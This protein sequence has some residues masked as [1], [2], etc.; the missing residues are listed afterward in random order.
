M[1]P[2]VR[3]RAL[4]VLARAPSN[5]NGY[6]ERSTQAAWL[7]AHVRDTVRYI[8]DGIEQYQPTMTTLRLGGDCDDSARALV[9]LAKSVGLQARLVAP[10]G[11]NHALAEIHDGKAWRLA[12]TTLRAARYGEEPRAAL[13]RLRAEGIG[14]PARPDLGSAEEIN[15]MPAGTNKT[16]T[17]ACSGIAPIYAAGIDVQARA[18]ILA[19]WAL[20]PGAPVK[21]PQWLQFAQAICRL[22]S[23]YGRGWKA[24]TNMVGSNNWGATQCGADAIFPGV[25]QLKTK[26]RPALSEIPKDLMPSCKPGCRLSFDTNPDGTYYLVCFREFASPELGAAD[27][28]KHLFK[29]AAVVAAVSSG[30]ATKLS[31]AMYETKYFTGHGSRAEA[32]AAHARA[33]ECHAARIAE[34]VGEPHVI[35]RGGAT[36]AGTSALWTALGIAAAGGVGW[37]AWQRY[38][39][40][41]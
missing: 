40:R 6:L 18:T 12:E 8:E 20:V 5:P 29:R 13:R 26:T 11:L 36:S 2:R 25:I 33:T 37:L 19:A 39:A 30:D 21:S 9:A 4:E 15:L 27:V 34:A 1:D 32:I 23:S 10:P 7:H 24:D 41:A 28:L 35:V 38:G 22:E 17:T 31:T 16:A 3:H 14:P